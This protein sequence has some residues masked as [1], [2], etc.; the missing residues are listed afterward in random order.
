MPGRDE[1]FFEP[2]EKM[3]YLNFVNFHT[4][5]YDNHLEILR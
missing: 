2:M 4:G 5:K 3:S 1:K